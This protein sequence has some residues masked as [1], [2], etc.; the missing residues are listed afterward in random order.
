[1][2]TTERQIRR[3]LSVSRRN[4]CDWEIAEDYSLEWNVPISQAIFRIIREYKTYDTY[5][6]KRRM[7]M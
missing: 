7:E 5:I 3:C 4:D 1:M 6:K 2:K